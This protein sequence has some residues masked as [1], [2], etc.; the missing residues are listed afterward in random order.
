LVCG[1]SLFHLLNGWLGDHPALGDYVEDLVSYWAVPVFLLAT[2]SLWFLDRPGPWYRFKIAC[3]SGLTAAGLGL[4]TS[5][6]ITHFWARERPFVAHPHETV[7]LATP[8]REPSFPSD[9]AIAAFAIAFSVALIGGRRVGAL[10]LAA[11]T[12]IGV[13]R[14]LVGLHYPSDIVGGALIGFLSAFLVF[15]TSG[16]RWVPIVRLLSRVTDPL[17][18]PA[19]NA[20]D[21]YKARRRARSH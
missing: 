16:G 9:H 20:L 4:L 1:L 2:F 8:S 17:V 3:L 10:F 19:W 11:A 14:V 12:L 6:V 7:L 5:Q 15:A 21:A 18:M 13:T